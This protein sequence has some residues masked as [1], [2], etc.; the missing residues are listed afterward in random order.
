MSKKEN[1]F[2]QVSIIPH[3]ISE[4]ILSNMHKG[5]FVNLETD[6]VGRYIKHFLRSDTQ[7]DTSK[8]TVTK[9]LLC[10]NGFI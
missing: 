8:T 3:T 10:E 2:F 6:I 9:A 5:T 1:T 4:T 7:K